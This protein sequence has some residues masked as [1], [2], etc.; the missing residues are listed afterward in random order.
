METNRRP[1]TTGQSDKRD[2][3]QGRSY[4]AAEERGAARSLSLRNS[5]TKV[6]KSACGVLKK[7]L[8]LLT[9]THQL[10]GTKCVCV[11]LVECV[12]AECEQLFINDS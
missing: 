9:K 10:C 12:G 1:A 6:S 3:G 11:C 8:T 2:D 7:S 4:R 5:P